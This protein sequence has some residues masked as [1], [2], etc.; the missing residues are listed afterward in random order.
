MI[1]LQAQIYVNIIVGHGW[2]KLADKKNGKKSIFISL[3]PWQH[4]VPAVST[5][6]IYFWGNIYFNLPIYIINLPIYIIS[7][8]IYIINLPI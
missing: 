8:P 7:L 1:K 5:Y 2:T 3:M 4:R 6:Y